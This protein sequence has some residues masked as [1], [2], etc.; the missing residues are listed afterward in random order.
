LIR[1]CGALRTLPASA[2]TAG[3]AVSLLPPQNAAGSNLSLSLQAHAQATLAF[4]PLQ[5]SIDRAQTAVTRLGATQ[6]EAF[7]QAQ[8]AVASLGATRREAANRSQLSAIDEGQQRILRNIRGPAIS[9]RLAH[10]DQELVVSSVAN[11]NIGGTVAPSH[12]LTLEREA[13]LSAN[14]VETVENSETSAADTT[15]FREPELPHWDMSTVESRAQWTQG[16][17]DARARFKAEARAVGLGQIL[18]PVDNPSPA[19]LLYYNYLMAR[20]GWKQGHATDFSRRRANTATGLSA[21]FT[22][23]TSGLVIKPASAVADMHWCIDN[24]GKIRADVGD[25]RHSDWSDYWEAGYKKTKLWGKNTFVPKRLVLGTNSMWALFYHAGPD[26]PDDR[27]PPHFRD[28]A[29]L[30]GRMLHTFGTEYI[31]RDDNRRLSTELDEH[32]KENVA[33]TTAALNDA[34]KI[35]TDRHQL[36]LKQHE[37]MM[38][39]SRQAIEAA[40]LAYRVEMAKQTGILEEHIETCKVHDSRNGCS[41]LQR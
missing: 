21:S 35:I 25:S 30:F 36:Q 22:D 1:G 17:L 31:S 9:E 8:I 24:L 40:S 18:P 4:A 38:A 13:A 10:A 14:Y 32:L 39:Q 20:R 5:A 26:V 23:G 3:T 2:Q 29:E 37:D 19:M 34:K 12:R 27:D 16:R 41:I 28:S 11:E 15:S 7:D 6:R 33:K